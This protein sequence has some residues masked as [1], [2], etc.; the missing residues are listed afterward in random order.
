MQKSERVKSKLVHIGE[1]DSGVS[2][3]LPWVLNVCLMVKDGEGGSKA[4][5]T[6]ANEVSGRN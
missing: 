3:S 2:W 6:L 1:N 4:S 5:T